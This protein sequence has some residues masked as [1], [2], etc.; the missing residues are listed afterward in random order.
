MGVSLL[1]CSL[2]VLF[3]LVASLVPDQPNVWSDGSPCPTGVSSSGTGFFGS[4]WRQRSWLEGGV[5]DACAHGGNMSSRAS[6]QRW[7]QPCITAVMWGLRSTKPDGDRRRPTEEEEEAGLE[8]FSGLWAPTPLPPGMR[9]AS[10]AEPP[11]A[12]EAGPEAHRGAVW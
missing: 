5:K 2:L 1:L 7:S 12:Q 10:L 11:G 9:P 3:I 4:R 8:T 6:R